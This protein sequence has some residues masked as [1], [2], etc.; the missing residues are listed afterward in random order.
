MRKL[1]GELIQQGVKDPRIGFVTIT[2]VRVT[3]DLGKA[4][5]YYTVLGGDADHKGTEAGLRSAAAFLRTESGRRLRLKTTPE[6][7]F[8][9]D[10]APVRGERVDR[11]IDQAHTADSMLRVPPVRPEVEEALEAA[12]RALAGDDPVA[13]ACHVAPDGDALGSILGLG[14]ALRRGGREVRAS[15]GSDELVVPDQLAFLPGLDMLEPPASLGSPP[16]AVAL[17]C[18]SADRLD[19]LRERFEAA[20]VLVNVD[21]H[22]SNTRFGTID[23]V[24]DQAPSTTELVLRLLVH[25]GTPLTPEIAL[26]LYVGLYTDTGRF[27]YASATPRAHEAA[28]AMISA[29]GV[30]PDEVSQAIYESL[31]FGYLK[32][33]GRVLDRARFLTDPPMVTSYQTQADLEECGIAY[34]DTD[35]VINVLRSTAGSDV[36]C[37][38]KELDDGTWKGSL[39]SKRDTDVSAIATAFGGGGH[40]LAAGFTSTEGRDATIERVH[41]ALRDA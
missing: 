27:S 37:V 13:L 2:A 10:D 18:A 1:L 20:D 32:L 34:E 6:L 30:A 26:C 4:H 15:W 8:H 29:G 3:P 9:L 5:V 38:L 28:A 25:L 33:L 41:R 35:D 23:V 21:H 12:A 36:A 11:I 19:L 14:L 31:P 24:D 39:R 7:V 16:V 17:D 40:A 22:V